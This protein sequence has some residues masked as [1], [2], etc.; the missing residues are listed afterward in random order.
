MS[1]S[2]GRDVKWRMTGMKLRAAIM[3]GGYSGTQ[4]IRARSNAA[5]VEGEDGGKSQ[6]A[7]ASLLHCSSPSEPRTGASDH[8]AGAA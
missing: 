2:R 6:G 8:R 1:S 4:S 3:R 7:T 5:E